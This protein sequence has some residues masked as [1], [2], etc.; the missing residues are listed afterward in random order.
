ML[1]MLICHQFGSNRWCVNP[2]F[3]HLILDFFFA[4]LIHTELTPN[5]TGVWLVDV[6]AGGGSS[7]EDVQCRWITSS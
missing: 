5:R 3:L 4:F 2:S 6:L 1:L 7:S